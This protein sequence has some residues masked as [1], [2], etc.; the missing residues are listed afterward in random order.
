M[1]ERTLR[2]IEAVK[3]YSFKTGSALA[4][5]TLSNQ[6]W[7]DLRKLTN[8]LEAYSDATQASEGRFATLDIILPTMDFLLETLETG[9]T[10]AEATDDTFLALCCN[11]GWAKLNKYYTLTERSAAFIAAIVCVHNSSGNTSRICSGQRIGLRLLALLCRRCG[12]LSIKGH[13]YQNYPCPLRILRTVRK[14]RRDCHIADL[15]HVELP[16]LED[17]V[18]RMLGHNSIA[19]SLLVVSTTAEFA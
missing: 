19:A 8:F 2:L 17:H 1:L 11:A 5:D 3:V 18:L 15:R 16:T 7:D 14:E 12:S 13:R 4:E 6:E 9:K 10:E